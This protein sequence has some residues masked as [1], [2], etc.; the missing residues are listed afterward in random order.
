[1]YVYSI[2]IYLFKDGSEILGECDSNFVY[3]KRIFDY[4]FIFWEIIRVF[5][6]CIIYYLIGYVIYVLYMYMWMKFD[7]RLL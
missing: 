2:F 5:I 3:V 1:M 7:I 4:K 6:S